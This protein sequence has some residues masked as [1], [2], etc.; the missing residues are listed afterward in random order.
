MTY[1]R[2]IAAARSACCSVWSGPS[3]AAVPVRSRSDRRPLYCRMAGMIGRR[4]RWSRGG[5]RWNERPRTSNVRGLRRDRPGP[6]APRTVLR[7]AEGSA[8]RKAV[9]QAGLV[10]VGPRRADRRMVGPERARTGGQDPVQVASGLVSVAKFVR[11][12]RQLEDERQQQGVG[13]R[14][15]A[16]TRRERLLRHPAG[17]ARVTRLP[18]QLCQE[19]RGVQHLGMI[20]SVRRRMGRLHGVGE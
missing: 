1:A 7:A 5:R 19:V 14:P 13:I 2:A 6:Q 8:C 17:G 20:R 10:E 9:G 11:H 3:P 16:F 15:E 12:G 18:V 4:T